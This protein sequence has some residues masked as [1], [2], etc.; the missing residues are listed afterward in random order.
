MHPNEF[1]INIPLV[2]KLLIEQFPCWAELP[3]TPVSSAGTDNALYRLGDDRVVRLPR[4]DWAVKDVEKEC[5]WLPKIAPFLPIAIP[6]PLAKGV[7]TEDYPRPWSVYNWLEGSNPVVAQISDLLT[8]DLISFIRALHKAD[9]PNGPI[10]T[11][12]VP[13]EKQDAETRKALQALDG[14][15]DVR[16]LT[17]IWDTALQAPKWSK[18]PVWVHGDL[19]PGNLLIQNGRLSAVIDFGNLGIGDPACD[20]IIAW[21]L[22][23]GHLRCAF[24][25]GLEIDDATWQRGRGWALSVALIQLPY[26]KDTNPTL[27][28]SARHVIQEILEDHYRHSAFTFSPAKVSQRSLLHGWFEQDHIQEWMHGIGLQNT[29]TGLENFFEGRSST[30]YWVGYDKDIPFAFLITSPEGE[31]AITLDLFICN[32]DYLGKGLAV[33][34]I[35][36]FLMSQFPHVKKVLIDPEATNARAIHVYKKVGFKIIEEFIASWHP[37]PHYLMELSMEHL[38]LRN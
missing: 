13:L 20:L 18:L 24:R 17:A 6:L 25:E 11:R 35:Q 8:N 27:A 12:G 4:I 7:P 34:M 30:T 33:P 23:P 10:S 28:N 9:L 14:I 21:N 3:L 37:V 15:V 38:H 19:S 22:L 29:L 5:E 26:Y 31:D 32:L 2:Q 16:T 36:G 1:E